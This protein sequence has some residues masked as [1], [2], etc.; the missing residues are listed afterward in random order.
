MGANV[1]QTSAGREGLDVRKEGGDGEGHRDHQYLAQDSAFVLLGRLGGRRAEVAHRFGGVVGLDG[2]RVILA[3]GDAGRDGQALALDE[4]GRGIE[5]VGFGELVPERAP[6][7]ASGGRPSATR[8]A[9]GAERGIAPEV[10]RD[11]VQRLAGAYQS[12]RDIS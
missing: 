6:G 8:P 1:P 11:Q 7:R 5:A 2:G 9:K 3:A 4:R 10:R 12:A